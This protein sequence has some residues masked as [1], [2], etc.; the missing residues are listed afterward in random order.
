LLSLV[1]TQPDVKKFCCG[2]KSCSRPLTASVQ[3]KNR[4]MIDH[5]P[6]KNRPTKIRGRHSLDAHF[7]ENAIII[8]IVPF[9]DVVV[10]TVT[11]MV[12]KMASGEKIQQDR[13]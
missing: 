7:S 13:T 10:R 1:N 5:L 9:E 3:S 2:P 8:E 6:S 4:K 11:K 12:T